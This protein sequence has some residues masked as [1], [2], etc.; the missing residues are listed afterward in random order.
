MIAGFP[1]PARVATVNRQRAALTER[2]GD[3]ARHLA[4]LD[5][6]RRTNL[7]V[8]RT[9]ARLAKLLTERRR[10][11]ALARSLD[12]PLTYGRVADACNISEGAVMQVVAKSVAESA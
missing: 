4:V 1:Q 2:A 8:R 6:A 5:Q 11:F 9:E 12:P 10:L 7:A 3:T